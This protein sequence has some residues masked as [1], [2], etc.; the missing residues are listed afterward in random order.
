M[1]DHDPCERVEQVVLPQAGGEVGPPLRCRPCQ[2]GGEPLRPPRGRSTLKYPLPGP[3]A[4][5]LWFVA[6]QTGPLDLWSAAGLT[7]PT[8]GESTCQPPPEH[9]ECGGSWG[10]RGLV[11][12]ETG[13]TQ[14]GCTECGRARRLSRDGGTIEAR[15]IVQS[16]P[17][18]R[19][20]P[21]GPDTT[22]SSPHKEARRAQC[23][24]ESRAGTVALIEELCRRNERFYGR[25]PP[26]G[27]GRL[28][29]GLRG[30][31]RW[32]RIHSASP[33]ERMSPSRDTAG[34]GIAN[35]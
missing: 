35:T 17:L 20:P 14:Q 16:Q 29:S 10:I 34:L 4:P 23:Q 19:I 13:V 15:T 9:C 3:L 30:R 12:A 27:P 22:N 32:V 31:T 21:R 1:T 2:G 11:D 25:G 26:G 6:S 28:S 33:G 24:E 5:T 8:A 7:T 18:R